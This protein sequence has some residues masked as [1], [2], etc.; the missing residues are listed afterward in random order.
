VLLV[1]AAD[2]PASTTCRAQLIRRHNQHSPI[3]K[4]DIIIWHESA[5][6]TVHTVNK[7]DG[8]LYVCMYFFSIVVVYLPVVA[9]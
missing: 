4:V 8:H 2:V 9:L 6:L 1:L 3:Q 5:Y 7:Q